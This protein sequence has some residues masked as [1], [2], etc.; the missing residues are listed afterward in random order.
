MATSK[1]VEMKLIRQAAAAAFRR[2][3]CGEDTQKPRKV[4]MAYKLNCLAKSLRFSLEV[5]PMQTI[6]APPIHLPWD[7]SVSVGPRT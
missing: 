5:V 6:V 7:N 2:D 4:T 3:I 1:N